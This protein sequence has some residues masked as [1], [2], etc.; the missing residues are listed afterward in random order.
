MPNFAF[1]SPVFNGSSLKFVDNG[2]NLLGSSTVVYIFNLGERVGW[3]QNMS[4]RFVER[5]IEEFGK[6]IKIAEIKTETIS[7][8]C[9]TNCPDPVYHQREC[10][11]R[12]LQYGSHPQKIKIR[13]K[14]GE[15]H[16]FMGGLFF[17]LK[18]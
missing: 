18:D 2:W 4:F 17:P 1:S 12:A 16:E 13:N 11:I 6:E 15:E 14:K 8:P 3:N 7:C 10:P 9:S 5:L